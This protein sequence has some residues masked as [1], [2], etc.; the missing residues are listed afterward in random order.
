MLNRVE[1]LGETMRHAL[2]N[3]AVVAPTWLRPIVEPE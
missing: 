2:D 1:L 3:L